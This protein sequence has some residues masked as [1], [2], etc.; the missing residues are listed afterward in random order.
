MEEVK[1]GIFV[2]RGNAEIPTYHVI[3]DTIPEA[4]WKGLYVVHFGGYELRTQYDRKN[5]DGSFIDPP[6]RDAAV[7]IEIKEPLK[8]PRHPKVLTSEIGKLI[9]EYLGAKDHLVPS[10]ET[11]FDLAKNARQEKRK[12]SEKESTKWPYTYFKRLTERPTHDGGTFNQLEN[13]LED[14]AKSPI[15]RRAVAITAVPEID[16]YMEADQP[17]L[18]EIQLRALEYTQPDD[19]KRKFKLGMGLRWRSRDNPKAWPDNIIGLTVL[20][21]VLARQLSEKT[22]WDV[23]PGYVHDFSE[24]LHIYG[25]DYLS[26][27]GRFNGDSFFKRFPTA[28][29]YVESSAKSWPQEKVLDNVLYQLRDFREES[30]WKFTPNAFNIIDRLIIDFET[31][32]LIP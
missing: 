10:Y 20:Q 7:L 25:Q 17:C 4:F 8:Q 29:S 14:L 23:S 21:E 2:H 22:G 27:G 30:T 9:A 5:S 3:A 11:L 31:G 12:I 26:T 24:S 6:G 32:K 13:N 1:E 16:Q 28:E 19:T 18:R 15:S